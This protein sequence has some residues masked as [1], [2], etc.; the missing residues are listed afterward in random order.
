MY[1][2]RH[3]QLKW[4]RKAEMIIPFCPQQFFLHER[5]TQHW[6]NW[7]QSTIFRMHVLSLLLRSNHQNRGLLLTWFPSPGPAESV[8]DG[9]RCK[10]NASLS[11]TI[12]LFL[13]TCW[14]YNG[15][16]QN[17]AHCE[18]FNTPSFDY[19]GGECDCAV[20]RNCP[21]RKIFAAVETSI[22]CIRRYRYFEHW[23][24]LCT[25]TRMIILTISPSR[26]N[27][28]LIHPYSQFLRGKHQCLK[29][30]F[31]ARPAIFLSFA[32]H[33]SLFRSSCESW[34]KNVVHVVQGGAFFLL[35]DFA[36]TGLHIWPW[37][38]Q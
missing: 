8:A 26:I 15:R 38:P 10:Q 33:V 20:E 5:L 30:G 2:T 6:G 19:G 29:D 16:Q 23:N 18:D 35:W 21:C 22:I 24:I 11:V 36:A 25:A 1:W 31:E 7:E 4:I 12:L 34:S 3:Y 27:R 37:V 32:R 17:L 13:G 28:G 14:I 9:S